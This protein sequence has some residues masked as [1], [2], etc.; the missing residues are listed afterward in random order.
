MKENPLCSTDDD[1][2]EL[3]RIMLLVS[4]VIVIRLAVFFV[5]VLTLLINSGGLC[6]KWHQHD[7]NSIGI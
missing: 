3:T 4:V 7:K 5:V 1:A 6:S 2:V